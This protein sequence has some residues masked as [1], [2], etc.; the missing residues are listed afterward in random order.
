MMTF[1]ILALIALLLFIVIR[2]NYI[3]EPRFKHIEL[4]RP[5]YKENYLA[6]FKFEQ[7]NNF[8]N[9]MMRRKRRRLKIKKGAVF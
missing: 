2:F 7:T 9:A 3:L 5:C 4:E 6:T 1:A 8:V